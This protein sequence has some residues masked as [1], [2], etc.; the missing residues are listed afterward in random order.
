MIR[1]RSLL[2]ALIICPGVASRA[3]LPPLIPREV[4]F[5]NPERSDPQISPDG[6][7]IAWLAPDKND[8]L[9]VWAS[10]IDGGKPHP[11]TNEAHRPIGW[12]AWGGDGKHVLYL[13]DVGGDENQHLLSAD[14]TNGNVRDL[15]PFRGVRAQN[16]MTDFQHPRFVLVGLNLR[17]RRRLRHVSRR[18]R[19]GRGYTG[20][21]EPR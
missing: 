20:S 19:D 21:A 5:G 11:I 10:A 18:C 16:V 1:L 3:E 17:D 2:L 8:V 6:R 14:L 9:N 7:Q 13:Q 4:F 15:T 12:Y